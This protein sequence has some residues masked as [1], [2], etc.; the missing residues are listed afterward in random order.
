MLHRQ[1][2]ADAAL[3]SHGEKMQVAMDEKEKRRIASRNRTEAVVACRPFTSGG[4]THT[5]E[6]VLRNFSEEGSYIETS[7]EF[8][9]G[10]ILHLR[11]VHY[12][13]MQLSSDA[14]AQPR[15]ICLAEVKWRQEMVNENTIQYGLGLRYLD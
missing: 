9:L 15:T 6:G 14:E 7:R 8:K 5:E 12:P 4:A 2:P 3:R 10:T 1:K 11:M 13:P